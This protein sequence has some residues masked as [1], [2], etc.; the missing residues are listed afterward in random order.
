MDIAT[1]TQEIHSQLEKDLSESESA[2]E[3]EAL[4]VKYLGKKGLVQGLMQYLRDI[5][6]DE[7]PDFGKRINDLKEAVSERIERFLF[8][9]KAVELESRL[10]HERLDVTLPGR[11]HWY[12]GRHVILKML[13]EAIDILSRMG[14]SVQE[15]PDIE[16]DYYNFESLNFPKD[17]PSRDM[18]DTFYITSD[19]LLRTHTS[20]VQVRIMEKECP[21]IRV[22]AAGKCYRSE[23][24]SKRSHVLFHQVEGFYIDEH[25]TFANLI[26]TLKEFFTKFF[27]EEIQM[28][29][30]PSYFP[31]VEPGMEVDIHCFLC[32][33]KGCSVCKKTGWLEVSGAGM[34]HPEV[35]KNGGIDT[36]KYTGYAW[37][38]GIERL[39]M[40][41]YGV[42][43]I[44]LFMEN[45]QRFLQQ[46]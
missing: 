4:K 26:A 31:F 22:I 37:A 16:T 42:T 13:D 40:L 2:K 19:I 7:R 44:R 46:F 3:I 41:R 11:R 12:G 8:R 9:F 23:D 39:A 35:L 29:F 33:G 45:N 6:S 25:V 34:I 28:R 18:Q 15:G 10:E 1:K 5:P 14:F 21:P 36:E 20:N 27:D 24:I 32:R 43:D 38:L 30:R 17:H